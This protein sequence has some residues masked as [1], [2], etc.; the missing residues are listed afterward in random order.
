MRSKLS[1]S[2]TL[3]SPLGNKRPNL[4]SAKLPLQELQ[5]QIKFPRISPLEY[6]R[7]HQKH[8]FSEEELPQPSDGLLILWVCTWD[9]KLNILRIMIIIIMQRKLYCQLLQFPEF[10]LGYL[11]AANVIIIC[12]LCVWDWNCMINISLPLHSRNKWGFN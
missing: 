5:N 6:L 10:F 9:L 3:S 2:C 12:E 4:P 11:E 8:T 7:R 1:P